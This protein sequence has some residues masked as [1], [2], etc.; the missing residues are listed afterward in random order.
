MHLQCKRP[1]FDSWLRE[2]C[3]R[4]D[5]LPTPVLL[6]FHCGS[7]GK[8]SACH[9]GDLSS[10]PGLGRSPG[11]RKGYP[12]QYSGLENP[13]DSIVHGVTKS[14]TQQSNFYLSWDMEYYSSVLYSKTL[15]CIHPVYTSWH[16]LTPNSQTT[17]PPHRSQVCSLHLWVSFS[18]VDK[19]YCMIL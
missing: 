5:R 13:M 14:L 7:S 19:L 8:E 9:A 12:L 18:F 1:Q 11:E 15:L 16:H 6:G 10:I 2:I 4:R 3:W 17:S